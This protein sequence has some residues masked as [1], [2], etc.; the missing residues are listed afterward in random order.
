[1][2]LQKSM[3]LVTAFIFSL[4]SIGYARAEETG[5]LNDIKPPQQ[6]SEY[7]F[8]SSQKESLITVQL[9]GAVNKPGI[10]YVPQNTDLLKLITLAGGSTTAG[11]VS[12]V[13]VRKQEPKSWD[14]VKSKAINE[15]QGAYEVNAEKI[16]KYGGARQ[17]K[18]AQDDFVYVPQKST[19]VSGEAT[20][21]ITVVSLVAGIV[22]TGLLIQKNSDHK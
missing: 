19:W 4:S 1:M 6:A 15:Y 17:L 18:L 20:K 10:Y 22:L 8:R 12:E 7:I 2:N 13:L 9:M 11:D 5:L 14:E 3:C 16:I 21:T